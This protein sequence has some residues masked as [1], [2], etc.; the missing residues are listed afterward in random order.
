M[1]NENFEVVVNVIGT[2]GKVI[3]TGSRPATAGATD[4]YKT[5][6][7]EIEYSDMTV[8][9]KEVKITFASTT[10]T[11][12]EIGTA[13]QVNAP[14]GENDGTNITAANAAFADYN[15]VRVGSELRIDNVELI[16][17]EN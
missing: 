9:A 11:S 12:P 5:C 7:V 2:T 10:N 3:G 4:S 15:N 17:T 16:Y 6:K 8:K 14:S 13:K 1:N